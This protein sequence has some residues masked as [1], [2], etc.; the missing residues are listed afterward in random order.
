L[1]LHSIPFLFI[2][3]FGFL[4]YAIHIHRLFAS[5]TW[6]NIIFL[7]PGFTKPIESSICSNYSI[8][9]IYNS[10]HFNSPLLYLFWSLWSADRVN[11][12]IVGFKVHNFYL[13]VT[14]INREKQT[15]SALIVR[16]ASYPAAPWF[17]YK[18]LCLIYANK[19]VET[20]KY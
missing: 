10:N 18:F 16:K 11:Q 3:L 6:F 19:K 13:K 7:L 20:Y 1:C 9:T 5:R 2:Y 12:T 17:N 4:D 15:N 8:S 14:Q